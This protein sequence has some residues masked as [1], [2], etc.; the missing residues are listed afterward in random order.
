MGFL[1]T[2]ALDSTNVNYAFETLISCKK[3]LYSNLCVFCLEIYEEHGT[4]ISRKQS[5]ELIVSDRQSISVKKGKSITL[6]DVG[7]STLKKKRRRIAKLGGC[8]KSS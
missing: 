4:K 3:F 5:E 1:E 8:C 2:S 7:Q 6:E